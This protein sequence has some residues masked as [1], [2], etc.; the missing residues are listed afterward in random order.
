[1]NTVGSSRM[2]ASFHNL[3]SANAAS[4][5]HDLIELECKGDWFD[6]CIPFFHPRLSFAILFKA[7]AW[8]TSRSTSFSTRCPFYAALSSHLIHVYVTSTANIHLPLPSLIPH[9][10]IRD[11][12]PPR[13][14][15]RRRPDLTQ[16]LE[17][18]RSY[19]GTAD[20]A[21][22]LSLFSFLGGFFVFF[23]RRGGR[24]R[25]TREYVRMWGWLVLDVEWS[26]LDH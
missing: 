19:W 14:R 18:E 7:L 21:F 4:S 16:D 17:Y 22:I 8:N 20:C 26:C 12:N 6:R 1:M 25:R 15:T 10:Q 11:N 3:A 2:I 5:S 9:P 24:E 23:L 13:H